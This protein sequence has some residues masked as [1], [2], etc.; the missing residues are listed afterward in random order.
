MARAQFRPLLHPR[1]RAHFLVSARCV[2]HYL[3]SG[4]FLCLTGRGALRLPFFFCACHLGALSLHCT[5][6]PLSVFLDL[7][8]KMEGKGWGYTQQ[9]SF[10]QVYRRRRRGSMPSHPTDAGP[11]TARHAGS[12][13]EQVSDPRSRLRTFASCQ[14][15]TSQ[16][17]MRKANKNS[18]SQ[19]LSTQGIE[20]QPCS[21]LN[22]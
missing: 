22:P 7:Q 3:W 1:A 11:S 14:R 4:Y 13:E 6:L 19:R 18:N 20:S 2:F 15:L 16:S 10:S 21:P 9:F 8:R 17:A 12:D 5:A